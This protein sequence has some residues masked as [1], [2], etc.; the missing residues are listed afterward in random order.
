[1]SNDYLRIAKDGLWDN[2][3]ILSML[4]GLCPTMAVTT[5]ATN[6]LGMGLATAVVMA[7][8]NI[9]VSL[10]RHNITYEVRVPVYILIVA[11]MV[12]LV[13]MV[14]N[15]YMHPMYKVLGLF[16][17]LIVS[18][19]LPLAHL[20]AFAGKKPP[21]ASLVDGLFAGLGFTLALTVIGGVREIIGSG[22][23]FSNA[24]LLLGPSF[25]FLEWHVLPS[26]CHILMMV[27][28]PG[29]FLITGLVL[30]GKRMID[31]AQG[32]EIAMSGAH[33]V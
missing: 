7:A 5:S 23:L 14:M 2:N 30:V 28:P 27:L 21:I 3:G 24:A 1:M 8:S 29:G 17:P 4:L 10:F 33:G 12:T 13:D 19:C 22:T 11:A 6:A 18:N 15:A 26:D 16:I 32:K 20:E 31:V 9:L 25:S